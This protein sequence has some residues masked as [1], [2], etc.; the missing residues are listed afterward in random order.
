MRS[1]HSSLKCLDYS[2]IGSQKSECYR[3]C[4]RKPSHSQF[5]SAQIFTCCSLSISAGEALWC[6]LTNSSRQP[7]RTENIKVCFVKPRIWNPLRQKIKNGN[8][9]RQN[10]TS[11]WCKYCFQMLTNLVC[12]K[13]SLRQAWSLKSCKH[14]FTLLSRAMIPGHP[15]QIFTK[16]Y[17]YPIFTLA[18][19]V[20]HVMLEIWDMIWKFKI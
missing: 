12:S 5:L 16:H 7:V 3:M 10:Q 9:W 19:S 15:W 20:R 18:K 13:V 8:G 14:Y 6:I 2:K 11:N 4:S 17:L 1:H